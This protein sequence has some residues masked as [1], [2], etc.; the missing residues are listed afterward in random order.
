MDPL[1][2]RSAL[3]DPSLAMG[4][5]VDLDY[6]LETMV[7]SKPRFEIYD[8]KFNELVRQHLDTDINSCELRKR[9]KARIAEL[10]DG[11]GSLKCFSLGD[12]RVELWDRCWS[13]GDPIF[14]SDGELLAYA[15]IGI[16]LVRSFGTKHGISE[17]S[18]DAVISRFNKV[19]GLIGSCVA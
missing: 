4:G 3:P 11:L 6:F 2:G 16:L 15:R 19:I 1:S 9:S 14:C 5:V 17:E 18:T 7:V 8:A 13:S 12:F 10:R